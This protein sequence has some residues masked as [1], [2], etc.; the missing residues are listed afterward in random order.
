MQASLQGGDLERLKRSIEDELKR[1]K[2]LTEEIES[3]L[4]AVRSAA[5]LEKARRNQADA[6]WLKD[7][8]AQYSQEVCERTLAANGLFP[9][10]QE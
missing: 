8:Q 1:L 2:A 7:L 3:A 10:A 4:G 5:I 6:N 9:I